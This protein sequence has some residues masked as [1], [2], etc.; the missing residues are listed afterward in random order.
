MK[1]KF[2]YE[3]AFSRNLGLLSEQEQE[4][5]R[6]CRIA[7]A[8][9]GGCGGLH[10][11]T[12]VRMGFCRFH[13]SDFDQFELV[14]FNRQYGA[15]GDTIGHNKAETMVEAAKRINPDIEVKLFPDGIHEDNI[16]QFLDG[17]QCFVDGLE[18]FEID[19]RRKIYKHAAEL[20]IHCTI[21]APLGFSTAWVNFDPHG[22]SFDQYFGF[23]DKQDNYSQFA[24]FLLGLAPSALHI[25]QIDRSKVSIASR[26]GP[27]LSLA[28]QLSTGVVGA[29]VL[30][31][32]LGRGKVNFAP[33]YNQFDAYQ[34]KLKIS[35][36]SFGAQNPW[37]QLKHFVLNR[38]LRALDQMNGKGIRSS[39]PTK[40]LTKNLRRNFR[41]LLK[42]L[43]QRF[44]FE[45]I[46]SS[47]RLRHDWL[48]GFEIRLAKTQAELEAA[49]RLLH[50]SYV[51]VGYMNA[52]PSGMRVLK[53]H[54][55]P[56]CSVIIGLWKGEV[57]ATLSLI[58]ENPFGLPSE[59]VFDFSACRNGQ[60][61][62]GEVSSLALS[63]AV[64]GQ[65]DFVLFPMFKF[66]Y[67]YARTQFG[68]DMFMISVVP[69]M[70]ELYR[71]LLCFDFVPGN[72]KSVYKAANNIEALALF[73]DLRLAD[74]KFREVNEGRPKEKNIHQFFTQFR[75]AENYRFPNRKYPVIFDSVMTPKIMKDLFFHGARIQ[76]KLEPKDFQVL[77]NE[78]IGPEYDQVFDQVS[79]LDRS[80]LLPQSRRWR[81][82][83]ADLKGQV[84][85]T[86][87][88]VQIQT[89]AEN[90]FG[91][92]SSSSHLVGE[93]LQFELQLG[94]TERASIS[95]K[96]MWSDSH[97]RHGLQ[98]NEPNQ[99]WARMLKTVEQAAD[100]VA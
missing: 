76:E 84:H 20:G 3:E 89:V 47:I 39:N 86:E 53:Q 34:G 82:Y 92:T 75:K 5:I 1:Q 59:K 10:L 61:R 18:I 63:P 12:L 32:V 4:R 24:S 33:G 71:C 100:Q 65:L 56:Q 25:K 96:V 68:V 94:E 93:T 46:R 62:L 17:V 13:I 40:S 55:L 2:I 21:A 58:R 78:Y 44:R 36:V 77:K 22:M 41:T 19:I 48:D 7:I 54:L 6:T 27:S 97:H 38:R 45:L 31:M 69:E 30:K 87:E 49:H 57:V 37:H 15:F 66:L 81:R 26:K 95:A 73:L 52:H 42:V 72:E 85:G 9:M 60:T 74:D 98:L 8:G 91:M 51:K 64:R 99:E 11:I 28:C 16:H 79:G 88:T 35:R 80:S 83:D 70:V 67:H 43:P 90:G 14:N 29:E 23:N 50:D